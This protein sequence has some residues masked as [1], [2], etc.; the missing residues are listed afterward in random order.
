M[1]IIGGT[2]GFVTAVLGWMMREIKLIGAQS[3]NPQPICSTDMQD[4]ELVDCRNVLNKLSGLTANMMLNDAVA[5]DIHSLALILGENEGGKIQLPASFVQ[6]CL[7][8]NKKE[9]C[10]AVNQVLVNW[11]T[12]NRSIRHEKFDKAIILKKMSDDSF[13]QFKGELDMKINK[14]VHNLNADYSVIS[15]VSCPNNCSAKIAQIRPAVQ[16]YYD[17]VIGNVEKDK[18]IEVN[19]LERKLRQSLKMKPGQAIASWLAEG[20]QD[21]GSE[22]SPPEVPMATMPVVGQQSFSGALDTQMDRAMVYCD[23]NPLDICETELDV[24]APLGSEIDCAI[25]AIENILGDSFCNLP[26][27]HMLVQRVLCRKGKLDYINPKNI[28]FHHRQVTQMAAYFKQLKDDAT[29][30]IAEKPSLKSFEDKLQIFKDNH[31]CIEGMSDVVSQPWKM[32]SEIKE[33]VLAREQSVGVDSQNNAALISTGQERK[34]L[35]RFIEGVDRHASSLNRVCAFLSQNAFN[36]SV[37]D[38]DS[39]EFMLRF[40][41]YLKNMKRLVDAKHLS[42]NVSDSKEP[43]QTQRPKSRLHSD[44]YIANQPRTT[45]LLT[46]SGEK[47]AQLM[48]AYTATDLYLV[49]RDDKIAVEHSNLQ[50]GIS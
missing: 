8:F 1:L 29:A 9:D 13:K 40:L 4:P 45:Y 42:Q 49:P 34:I 39:A 43:E 7:C 16:L 24:L 18:T 19:A 37:S 36:L 32:L 12:Q 25:K 33:S 2:G 17:N 11:V 41:S 48:A 47:M 30:S 10:E 20:A 23:S 27:K 28:H 31:F 6:H 26:A 44:F 5:L 22:S 50:N 38:E 21:S 46:S 3:S 14:R 15:I 35:D